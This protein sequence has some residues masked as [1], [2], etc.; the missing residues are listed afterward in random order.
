MKRRSWNEIREGLGELRA[1][2]P[3]KPA[4]AFWAEFRSRARLHPQLAPAE[5]PAFAPARKWILAGACATLLLAW[6]GLYIAG[7]P[8]TGGMNTIRSLDVVASNG[9]VLIMDDESTQSTI[10]WIV[11]LEADSAKEDSA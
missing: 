10:V 11:D 1:D 8:Q 3:P 7:R 4:D 9:G 6:A 5:R 2:R